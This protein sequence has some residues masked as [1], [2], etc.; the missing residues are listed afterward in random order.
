MG[1]EKKRKEKKIKS[2]LDDNIPTYQTEIKQKQAH[3]KRTQH[4]NGKN[5]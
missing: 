1:E 3:E 5:G 4:K 2:I